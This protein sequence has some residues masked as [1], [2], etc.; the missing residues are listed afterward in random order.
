M[1][2]WLVGTGVVIGASMV[3][4]LLIAAGVPHFVAAGVCGVLALAGFALQVYAALSMKAEGE[5]SIRRMQQDHEA[6]LRRARE[7]PPEEA[8]RLLLDNVK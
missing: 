1:K 6:L 2:N 4:A 7:L 8:V 5:R 3:W